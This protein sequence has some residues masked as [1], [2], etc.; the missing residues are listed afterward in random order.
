MK[1]FQPH[2]LYVEWIKDMRCSVDKDFRNGVDGLFQWGPLPQFST[3]NPA[4]SPTQCGSA[5]TLWKLQWIW[6]SVTVT[7]CPFVTPR[8]SKIKNV[9]GYC[10]NTGHITW[11]TIVRRSAEC[12]AWRHMTSQRRGWLSG[13]LFSAAPGSN[14]TTEVG[15][16]NPLAP[17]FPFKF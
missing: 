1:L 9:L 17:E 3:A 8:F 12:A 7:A 16:I 5:V 6:N 10:L 4:A 11:P 13:F 14:L 2:M 15:Y